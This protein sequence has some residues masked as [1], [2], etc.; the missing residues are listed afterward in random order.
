MARAM[1]RLGIPT[2]GE[3]LE[4]T[5]RVEALTKAVEKGNGRGRE[6]KARTPAPVATS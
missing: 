1:R 2:R 6:H 3:I 4:L 5:K